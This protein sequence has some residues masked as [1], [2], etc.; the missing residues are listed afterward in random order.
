M[1]RLSILLAILLFPV[2]LF[3]QV[4][5]SGG[6][7]GGTHPVDLAT[8]ITGTLDAT[9]V[10]GGPLKLNDGVASAP[11]LSFI[12]A[13]GGN[14]GI[15]FIS[16]NNIG[17]ATNGVLSWT[18]GLNDQRTE[19]PFLIKERADAIADVASYGQL[20]VNT[21]TPNELWFTD[22]AGTDFQVANGLTDAQV[23]NTITLNNLNQIA[24]RIVT[25]LSGA[26]TWKG[27]YTD[28]NPVVAE[29][30]LG[31]AGT[32]FTSNG[33]ASAPSFAVPTVAAS[34]R[35][36]LTADYTTTGSFANT[37]LDI[38]FTTGANK[39]LLNCTVIAE[40]SS[41]AS[42]EA[43][44]RFTVDGS[45]VEGGDSAG[46]IRSVQGAGTKRLTISAAYLTDALTAASHTFRVQAKGTNSL[47]LT[48]ASG[49]ERSTMAAVE[50]N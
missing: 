20:W 33:V 27:L 42:T 46:S 26:T 49:G 1:K 15:Y 28:G 45:T 12:T 19:L 38:T 44:I 29:F 18:W 11:T 16:D 39:V 35:D 25:T 50:I 6:G 9:S 21:A 5:K 23:D 24:T 40:W 2:G 41:T 32:V 7:G 8:D 48:G 47:V 3:G 37:G 43:D 30:A 34:G 14:D 22:D 10:G 36:I 13:G 31:A 17:F 4:I